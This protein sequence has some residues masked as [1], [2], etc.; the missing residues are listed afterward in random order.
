M[1]RTATLAIFTAG[2]DSRGGDDR[3]MTNPSGSPM[4][5][6]AGLMLERQKYEDWIATLE[7]KRAV[8]PPHVFERVREDYVKRLDA[9]TTQL[10]GRTAELKEAIAKLTARL[11]ELHARERAV[12]DER[13]EA[14]LRAAVGEYTPDAWKDFSTKS[15]AEISRL[16]SDRK[17]ASEEI[18]RLQQILSM[19]GSPGDAR[20]PGTPSTGSSKVAPSP[21]PE[22][23]AP[24]AAQPSADKGSAAPQR[25]SFDELAFLQSVTAPKE[26]AS[27]RSDMAAAPVPPPVPA[28][29][30]P[31]G[32][33]GPSGNV[34]AVSS[35]SHDEATE[36]PT[37]PPL[38]AT[39][40]QVAPRVSDELQPTSRDTG[41]MSSILRD[42]PQE[43]VKTL[44]CAEC[45][46]MNYPTEWYCERC[47]AELA[48]M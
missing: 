25:Q 12:T 15:D 46:A 36:S 48:A 2:T 37:A 43:H 21:A 11:A 24:R 33:R 5:A 20:P 18:G 22:S 14:E 44:K 32:R 30:Q 1:V 27:R 19:A 42:M 38:G 9:V 6:V 35:R 3:Q 4:D 10:R 41:P 8:T 23:Q 17:L 39:A 7:A 40:D 29:P 47:G 28:A 16:A 34:A 31:P 45:G 13:F 26:E